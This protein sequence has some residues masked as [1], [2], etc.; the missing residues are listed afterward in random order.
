[1]RHDGNV[2]LSFLAHASQQ[3]DELVGI[4]IGGESL[5]PETE[6]ARSD[7]QVLDVRQEVWVAH[8]LEVLRQRLR[9]HDHGISSG[10][11]DVGD[12]LVL[13]EVVEERVGLLLRES[14]LVVTDELRPSEAVRA[15]G[16]ARL[17]G[18]WEDQ[19]GLAVLVLD[20][21]QGVV[22]WRVELLLAGRVRVEVL[23]DFGT[24]VHQ[25]L[26]IARVSGR[27]QFLL[28]VRLEHVHGWEDE[29]VERV[30]LEVVRLPVDELVNVVRGCLEGEDQSCEL[31]VVNVR[32]N[33]WVV[34]GDLVD[35]LEVDGL[36][37]LV[38]LVGLDSVHADHVVETV[39]GHGLVG[40][41]RLIGGDARLR[42]L[43]DI[44]C[45]CWWRGTGAAEAGWDEGLHS[46]NGKGNGK[47][48]GQC[49]VALGGRED[50]HT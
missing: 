42:L 6:T 18:G 4:G 41:L 23:A 22:L 17:G 35:G 5:R 9:L 40:H 15:V 13:V 14:E 30:V 33:F 16:V 44:E 8:W 11:E 7:S 19:H 47:D 3:G 37:P 49:Q 34:L 1:M 25:L 24:R 10:H 21:R 29:T 50:R 45:W 43:E 28:V 12:L 32:Q 31:D 39:H 38:R 36:V 20:A 48:R 46:W 27:V 26:G 2:S